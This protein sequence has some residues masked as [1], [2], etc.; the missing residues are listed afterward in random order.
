[1]MQVRALLHGQ[2][3]FDLRQYRLNPPFGANIH[4]SRLVDLPLAGLILLLRPFAR[5]R[6][7][8]ADRGAAFAPLLPYLLL[9]FGLALTARRLIHPLRLSAGDPRPVLRRIDQR[10]VHARPHRP[11][12]LA[13]GAAR[14][15]A[16]P[17]SPTRSA[18]A[19]ASTLGVASALSLAIGLELLI[20]LALAGAATVLFWVADGDERRRL[21]GLC[22]EPWRR[23]VAVAS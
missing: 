9:L 18:R 17:G 22:G 3:W 6:R 20:Y 15:W 16:S 1:M 8:G 12:R 14:A 4:W 7:G 11:S 2:D 19:A 10:H 13:A 23:R 21:R 5:R